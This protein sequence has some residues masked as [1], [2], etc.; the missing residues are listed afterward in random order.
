MRILHTA[1]W[2][3]GDRLGRIDRT[4]DLRRAVERVRDHCLKEEV[5]VL[6]VAG[7]LFSELARA[8]ALREAIEHWQVV[9]S[10]FLTRGGTVLALTGNHDNENFCRTLHHAMSL[11]SPLTKEVGALLPCGRLYL[12]TQPTLLRLADRAGRDEVQFLLMPYPTPARYLHEETA[13]RYT[14][15]EEKNRRLHDAFKR[16]ME[17]L[18][19]APEFKTGVPVVLGAHVN[20][21]DANVSGP[22]FRMSPQDDVVVDL[23]AFSGEYDYVALGHIHKAQFLSGKKHIRYSGSIE[24]M[25]LGESDDVKSVVLIDLGPT[26]LKGEPRLL[27]MPATS[28]RELEIRNPT[29]ELE[30]LREEFAEC[31]EEL[32]NLHI[33]YTAGTDNLEG[34]LRALEQIFPRW[35]C[36]DWKESNALDGVLVDPESSS[37]GGFIETVR[38]YVKR[39][40]QNHPEQDVNELMGR[41]EALM[42]EID[43]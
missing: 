8:D 42:R 19:T 34:V 10:D 9:F 18:R 17:D 12:A 39:E 38:E 1:D 33:H 2:H 43:S 7:D 3:L 37:S 35:Y 14:T 15:H 21:R 26:G 20:L 27:P 32:V 31:S 11:A 24:R 25:D 22:L 13:Q 30:R 4:H 5:D 28:I 23:E 29:A 16:K 41:L 40:L 36:R 6:L